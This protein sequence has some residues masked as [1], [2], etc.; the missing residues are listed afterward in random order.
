MSYS[1]ETE[2]EGAAFYIRAY[3]WAGNSV[4]TGVW[5]LVLSRLPG[6]HVYLPLVAH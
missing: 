2:Q 6:Q 1:A 4:D 3:D 5:N